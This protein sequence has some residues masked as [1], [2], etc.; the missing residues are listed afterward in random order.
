MHR[1]EIW[2]ADIPGDKRRPVLILTR[3]RFIPFLTSVM[4]APLT[5]TVRHIPTEVALG[6]SDGVPSSCAANLD[7]TFTLATVRLMERITTLSEAR[8]E[9]IC[10]AYRFAAGC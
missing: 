7:N 3:E 1:G 8:L 5:T 6:L 4:V 10:S 9:Q 2:W